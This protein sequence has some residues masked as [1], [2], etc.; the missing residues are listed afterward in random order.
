[1]EHNESTDDACGIPVANDE[2]DVALLRPGSGDAIGE[3][4]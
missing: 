3:L 2:K 4:S 1:M